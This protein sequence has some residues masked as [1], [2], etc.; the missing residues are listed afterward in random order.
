MPQV[1]ATQAMPF[2][3]LDVWQL[4]RGLQEP[5][6]DEFWGWHPDSNMVVGIQGRLMLKMSMPQQCEREAQQLRCNK[7]QCENRAGN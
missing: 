3:E 4:Y 1:C 2:L 6:S 7:W 5:E